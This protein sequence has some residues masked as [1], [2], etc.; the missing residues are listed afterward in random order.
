M[1]HDV[2]VE[3]PPSLVPLTPEERKTMTL[4]GL[5]EARLKVYE[6]DVCKGPAR[7]TDMPRFL[8]MGDTTIRGYESGR[9]VPRMS[10]PKM[11]WFAEKFGVTVE[12]LALCWEN[13]QKLREAEQLRK[14]Q[15]QGQL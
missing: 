1:P 2:R 11:V 7:L 15:E 14:L 4:R 10:L 13:G 9:T 5:R 8:R 6:N 12:E 3:G